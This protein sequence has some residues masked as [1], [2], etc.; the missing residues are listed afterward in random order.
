MRCRIPL[1]FLTGAVALVAIGW[2]CD[3]LAAASL[4]HDPAL[5]LPHWM[6]LHPA[7][8]V[9]LV[10]AA[11]LGVAAAVYALLVAP[12]VSRKVLTFH[13]WLVVGGG[14]GLLL[15]LVLVDAGGLE[16][17][18]ITTSVVAILFGQLVFVGVTA[19]SAFKPPQVRP[20]RRSLVLS[21]VR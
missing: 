13:L 5:L 1:L 20:R 15:S 21:K 18:V 3:L 14:L 10:P 4:L 8:S 9:E 19:V 6:R 12:A 7:T 11:A 17:W 2:L 16:I